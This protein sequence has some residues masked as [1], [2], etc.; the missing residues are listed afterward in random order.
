MY[1]SS[2]QPAS[3]SPIGIQKHSRLGIA[4]F[5]VGIVAL[6]VLCLGMVLAFVYAGSIATQDL[7]SQITLSSPLV[8][9]LG[10]LLCASPVL[11]LVGFV[12]GL[13][14]VVQKNDKRTFGILGCII[15]ILVIF[16]FGVL[17]VIG[18]VAQSGSLTL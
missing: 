5:I 7:T 16:V 1:D 10:A 18:L 9:G 4:S 17:F 3:L 11:S 13:L 8:L 12:L 14:A 2:L 15:N 6:F